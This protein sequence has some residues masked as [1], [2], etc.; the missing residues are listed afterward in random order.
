MFYTPVISDIQ[1][2]LEA[3]GNPWSNVQTVQTLVPA[4]IKLVLIAAVVVFFFLLLWGG[5]RW[6]TAG[7]DKEKLA[8]AQ[9]TL[10][11]ALI[12]IVILLS[13]WAII[14]LVQNFFGITLIGGG[15]SFSGSSTYVCPG[16]GGHGCR[17]GTLSP[18]PCNYPP[19]GNCCI[20]RSSGL[21][22]TTTVSAGQCNVKPGDCQ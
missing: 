15:G 8:G 13:A 17:T 6:I 9:K 22:E 1:S 5:I 14:A 7:G 10:T 16:I 21:W 18:G 11:A 3:A 4:L 12:G 2:F 20:C 19:G